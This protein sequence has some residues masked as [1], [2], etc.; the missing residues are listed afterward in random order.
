MRHL[1]LLL[2]FCFPFG[3]M[4]Q[5]VMKPGSDFHLSEGAVLTLNDSLVL[6]SASLFRIGG[7]MTIRES[8]QNHGEIQWTGTMIL[9]GSIHHSGIISAVPLSQ[10]R[11]TGS[12]H[13]LGGD[14]SF[15]LGIWQN[16][17]SGI[18][19]IDVPVSV[20]AL[21]LDSVRVF[22]GN[23]PLRVL[24][25]APTALSRSEGWVVSGV[26]GALYRQMAADED[27]LFPVGDSVHYQAA[28]IRANELSAAGLRYS[29][30]AASAEGLP[31][32]LSDPL[33]CS[34]SGGFHYRLYPGNGNL[35]F[36]SAF[37]PSFYNNESGWAARGLDAGGSWSRLLSSSLVAPG[38]SLIV[39]FN[40]P[41]NNP[42]A[43]SLYA[44]RPETPSI[45]GLDSV[46]ALTSGLIYTVTNAQENVN[47]LWNVTGGN[48]LSQ[49]GSSAEINWGPNA[50]GNLSV[51]AS[52]PNGCSSVGGSLPVALHPL[53]DVSIL[54]QV[55]Q[56]PF[57][58][59]AWSFSAQGSGA[60]SFYWESGD[61]GSGFGTPFAFAYDEPG[62]YLA[63]L[64]AES[65]QGCRD[66]A[67]QKLSVVEGLEIPDAFS[68]NGDGVND[69]FLLKNGGL[70]DFSLQ[71]FDRWGNTVFETTQ[72]QTFWDGRT[73][74]G[75]L[76]PAGTYFFVLR[77]SGNGTDY[78]KRS[79]VSVYY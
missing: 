19:I 32:F 38:D 6:D 75:N 28:T 67:K 20:S 16:T 5:L 73:P 7:E 72:S 36:R 58:G 13:V 39:A 50:F 10:L 65:E 68:P 34:I 79:S 24:L 33:I 71:I 60:V 15:V 1:A 61:G 70:K 31:V 41:L 21:H 44:L 40:E 63:V 78:E 17:G 55:P 74:A 29:S 64:V 2:F 43:L 3:G 14:S 9:G 69:F 77:A 22:T 51:V 48:V 46:C 56:Y 25:D 76:V 4:S 8:V 49:G 52:A 62:D 45:A 42:V 54:M 27:Y 57:P 30:L 53:P 59:E 47:Y 18:R 26:G 12:L 23:Q 35:A 66:T 37:P 11:T